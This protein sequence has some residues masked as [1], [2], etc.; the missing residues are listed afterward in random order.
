[1][2]RYVTGFSAGDEFV[3]IMLSGGEHV[4]FKVGDMWPQAD[5]DDKR[6]LLT[7]LNE[8][9]VTI[10]R[11]ADGQALYESVSAADV[12]QQI[13]IEHGVQLMPDDICFPVVRELGVNFAV[14]YF[15]GNFHGTVKVCIVQDD[16]V[17]DGDRAQELHERIER[18]V[19]ILRKEK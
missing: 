6:K 16:V 5:D 13:L 4:Q 2:P 9:T 10:K 7:A 1:M 19:N 15:K 18:A 3:Q 14:T 8:K 17:T 11:T 12:R